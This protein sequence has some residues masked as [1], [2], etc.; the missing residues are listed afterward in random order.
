ARCDDCDNGYFNLTNSNPEGCVACNCNPVG[1]TTIYCDPSSGRCLC[2]LRVQ[3]IKCD[4]CKDGFYNFTSGCEDCLCNDEG[5]ESG[6]VCNKTSGQCTCKSNVEVPSQQP[7]PEYKERSPT[8]IL[9]QWAQPDNPNG[10]LT[11]YSVY[12][13]DTV[14]ANIPANVPS[15][16]PPPEYKERSPTSILLQW[17]QPDNPNGILTS[18]SVYRDDTVVASIPAN[19]TTYNDTGLQPYT[20]YIYVVEVTNAHGSTSSTP[21]IFQ[22]LAGTPSNDA[23][24]TVAD[25]RARS[26]FCSWTP[27]SALNGPLLK[28]AVLSKK[29]GENDTMVEWE[30]IGTSTN[31]TTLS[32]YTRYTLIVETCTAGGCTKNEGK[33]IVT[34]SAPPEAQRPPNISAVNSSTLFVTWDPPLRPNGIISFYEL[35]FRGP[36]D[37]EGNYNPPSSL[38]AHPSGRYD[39]LRSAI[40]TPLAWPQTNF[41]KSGLKPFTEYEFQVLAEND[42]GKVASEWASGTTKEAA[43]KIVAPPSVSGISSTELLITWSQPRPED[44]LGVVQTYR[45]FYYSS[46]DQVTD[47]FSPLYIWRVVYQG[48]GTVFQHTKSGLTPYSEHT[49]MLEACNS[50]ACANSTAVT[51]RT[52]LDV[53]EGVQTPKVEGFNTTAIR[54]SWDEPLFPNGPP[55]LYRVEK[56]NIALSFPASVVRGTRFT[57]G[58][59]YSFQ[60]NVIPQGV[61]FTGIRF[62][63][64]LDSGT[65]ILLF[66][67]S[68]TQEE[69]LAVQF[70]NGRPRFLFDTQG[71]NLIA[72]V[73]TTNDEGLVYNDGKWHSFEA[74]RTGIYGAVTV[75][76][77]WTGESYIR[78]PSCQGTSII[79][80]TEAVYV[81]GFPP[82]FVLRR[83][84]GTRRVETSALKGCIDNIEI[85]TQMYPEEKWRKLDWTKGVTN[86]LAFLNWQGCP[87]NLQPGFHFMGKGYLAIQNC[88][89]RSCDASGN[90]ITVSFR[91]RTTLHTGLL[92]LLYGGSNIYIYSYMDN[93]RL[94]FVL[95]DST[96]RTFLEYSNP[97]VNLCDGQLRALIFHKLGQQARILIEGTQVKA[98]GDPAVPMVLALTS[99]LHVGGIKPESDAAKFV[100]DNGLLVP[101]EG[102]GGCISRL[103]I[104][105]NRYWQE[106]NVVDVANTNLDGCPPFYTPQPEDTCQSSL[107]TQIYSGPDREAFDTGLLPYTD[108]IYRLVAA[109]DAGEGYSSWGYGRT[110]EG[111]PS[112][113]NAP[114]DVRSIS[115]YEVEVIWQEPEITYGLLTKYV[116]MAY[117]VG[118]Q[119]NNSQ[120]SLDIS[121]VTITAVNMTGLV[122]NTHYLVKVKACTPGGC[123]ESQDG[124]QVT[125]PI[126]APEDV[127]A[128]TAESGPTYLVVKWEIP[129]KPNGPITGFFLYQ[130]GIEIYSGSRLNFNVTNLHVYTVYKFH[131]A[132]CTVSGCTEGPSVAIS[133]AQLPPTFV[134][135][136][137]LLVLGTNSIRASWT[138]P[139]RLNGVLKSYFLYALAVSTGSAVPPSVLTD[140]LP[141][142]PVYNSTVLITFTTI[143]DLLAG[144]TYNITLGACTGGGCTL[145]TPAVATTEESA[146]QG[147]QEPI[148]NSPSFSSLEIKWEPPLFPNGQITSY[149]LLQN[150]AE[151]YNG[152]ERQYSVDGLLPYS[153]HTFR[154]RACT[155]QG[156]ATSE[157]V[158]ARTLEMPP[159]GNIV[160]S[161]NVEDA[162]T[163]NVT[164]TTPENLNGF[165]TYYVLAT[166]LYYVSPETWDYSTVNEQRVLLNET[167]GFTTYQLTPLVPM[168][169]Y[170]IQVNGSNSM[171]FILSNIVELDMPPGTPDGMAPPELISETPRSIRATW[172]PV[173]RVNAPEDPAYT[174]QFKNSE[175]AQIENEFG[176]T[177]TL[178]YVKMNLLP[179]TN[180]FFRVEV[181]NSLGYTLSD[182]ASL[183]TA[184]DKPG[185]MGLPLVVGV[186]A[187]YVDLSW[188]APLSPNG[189]VTNYNVYANSEMKMQVH[190][191]ATT[192]RVD[193][194]IP[195]TSYIFEVDVCTI[196]GCTKSPP[197]SSVRTLEDVPMDL[198]PPS[199]KALSPSAIE[200]EYQEPGQPNGQIAEY[201]IERKEGQ[202]DSTNSTVLVA[203]PPEMIKVYVDEANE[204]KPFTVYSY[205]VNVRN[206]AGLGIGPWAVVSTGASRPAGVSPPQVLGLDP[207]SVLVTWSPPL[208]PNGAIESYVLRFPDPRLEVRPENGTRKVVEG[209]T[210]YT[211]YAVTVTACT[212]GGCTESMP[213]RIRTESTIPEPTP[214]PSPTAVSSSRIS[215]LW[216]PSSSPNGPGINYELSRLKLK[217]PLDTTVTDINN[218]QSVYQGVDLFFEDTNLPMFT[219]YIYRVTVFNDKGQS[220]SQNSTQVTT[221]GGLPR[222]PPTVTAEPRDHLSVMV[223]WTLPSPVELQG[224]V[225]S[226]TLEGQSSIQNVTAYPPFNSAGYVLGSRTVL[227]P[228]TQYEITLTVTIY[229]GTS[230]TSEPVEV[231]TLSG[232]PSGLPPPTLAV[233][234]TSGL[235]V[236]W[237]APTQPNGDIISYTI[238]IG[239]QR[240]ETG[241][242]TPGS[243]IVDGLQPYTVYSVSMEAC[244]VFACTTSPSTPGTTAEAPP[245]GQPA[246]VLISVGSTEL[247]ISWT[248]PD[249]PNG[250]IQRYDLWRKTLQKC[251]DI[252]LPTTDPE[253]EKCTYIECGILENQCGRVCYSG[254]KECCDGNLHDARPGYGCCGTDYLPKAS[255]DLVCCAGKFYSPQENF[256]CCGRRYIH[257]PDGEICCAD[258]V[259]N[260]VSVSRGDACCGGIPYVTD[261]AQICCKN[262][263]W[264]RLGRQCCGGKVIPDTTIC[265]G[266]PDDGQDHLPKPG[267]SCCGQEYV[268]TSITLCCVSDTGES[269]VHYYRSN[270]DKL[271]ASDKCCGTARIS[272]NLGCCNYLSYDTMTQV[273]ADR[274]QQIT[275]CGTGVVCSLSQGATAFCNRCDFDRTQL[276]CGAVIGGGNVTTIVQ[277]SNPDPEAICTTETQWIFS[278]LNTTFT[279]TDLKPYSQY[280]YS[281]V[282]VNSAGSARS[283]YI[284]IQTLQAAPQLVQPPTPAVADGQ[285]FVFYVSWTVPER[286]N[287]EITEYNL[288]RDGIELYRGLAL[289]FT[290]NLNIL[291]YTSYSY[292]LS[293]C[294]EAGCT[295]SDLVSVATAQAAPEN[296]L[297]PLVNL[298]SPRQIK[299]MAQSPGLPNGI[300]ISFTVRMLGTSR[301]FEAQIPQEFLYDGLTPYTRYTFDSIVCTQA[302]CTTSPN[303]TV[304]TDQALPEGVSP[305]QIVVVSSTALNLY[306]QAPLQANGLITEYT[307]L[308]TGPP[309]VREEYTG[310]G[311]TAQ[312]R[313]LTPGS[314]L[315]YQLQVTNGAGTVHSIPREIVMPD[316][317][318]LNILPPQSVRVL[319]ST[320][321][322]IMWLPV[323]TNQGEIDQYRVLLNVGQETEV[324]RGVGPVTR[325]VVTEL[326][327]YTTYEIRL[328]ACLRNILNGCGTSPSI[329]VT[330]DEDIPTDL[331]PPIL[332]AV[333]PTAVHVSWQ[334]P[335][336]PNGQITLYRIYQRSVGNAASEI[337]INQ[338][339]GEILSFTHAGQDLQP[340][341]QY[342]YQV[343]AVNSIGSVK[344]NWSLVQTLQAPPQ[345]LAAPSIST[346][347]TYGISVSW[348]PP[349]SPNGPIHQYR[350]YYKQGSDPEQSISIDGNDT[351]TFVSGLLAYTEYQISIGA[352]NDAGSVRS[353]AISV[354]TLEGYPSGIPRLNVEKITTGTAVILTWEPPAQPNGEIIDYR[355][356]QSG[357]SVPVYSGLSQMFE[358]PRLLPFKQYVVSLEACTRAGCTLGEDQSFMTAET[359]PQNQPSPV[360]GSVNA[361]HVTLTWSSPVNPNGAITSYEVLRAEVSLSR[362]R[363]DTTNVLNMLGQYEISP[364]DDIINDPDENLFA[365]CNISN[366]NY[367]KSDTLDSMSF[368]KCVFDKVKNGSL[369]FQ[370]NKVLSLSD[371]YLFGDTDY[372]DKVILLH[373]KDTQS[374]DVSRSHIRS[375]LEFNTNKKAQTRFP[376]QAIPSPSEPIVV[377][378]TTETEGD[379]F[380]WT[381]S[382]LLPYKQYMY[383]V[384]ASNSKDQVTSPWQI[385][386]TEQAAPFGVKP[387]KLAH[388]TNDTNSVL[389][390]W[391]QPEQANGL[392]QGYQVQRNG[393]VPF[394]FPA[395]GERRFVDTGLSAF[396]SYAYSI[397]ACTGGGCTTSALAV[398][399][400]LEAP[401]LIVSPPIITAIDSSSVS[402][403]WIPPQ[404]SNGEVTQYV[405]NMDGVQ[406]YSGLAASFT[407]TGLLPYSAHVFTITACTNG[408]CT[409]S[410]EVTGR[411]ED[412]LPEGLSAPF[413]RV[414]SASAIEIVWS[415]P[416]RPNG[417][418]ESYDVR[419][420]GR[421][422]Y[423][424]SL[425]SN[426]AV[427]EMSYTDY[428]LEAGEEYSYTI[429]ARNRK[430]S[431]ESPSAKAVTYSASPSGLA[432][433]TLRPLT[434]SSIQ[435]DWL[436][437]ASP[438]GMLL[439]Y[440]LFEGQVLVYSGSSDTLSYTVPGLEAYTE[441]SFRVET[442]TAR[443]C[444]VSQPSL[445]RTL[446]APP[447]GQSKPSLLA[448]ADENGTHAGV[449]ITW[450]PPSKP[451]GEIT[452]YD[453]QRR[454]IL[455]G[456]SQDY[457]EA[458]LVYNGTLTGYIDVVSPDLKPYRVYQYMVS[459][460]NSAGKTDSP[461]ET[462]TTREGQPKGV[463]APVVKST[464]STTISVNTSVPTEPNGEIRLYRILVNGTVMSSSPAQ[465]QIVGVNR[466]LQ[467]FTVYELRV[468]ACTSGGC[469]LSSGVI[470]Q[471][472]SARPQ[473]LSAVQ[474]SQVTNES[475]ALTW[476]TPDSPNGVIQRYEIHQRKPCPKTFQPFEQTCVLGDAISIYTGLETTFTAHNLSPY[477]AYEFKLQA[478][479]EEGGVDF[480]QWVR[481]ETQ[482][483]DPLYANYPRMYKNG[484]L[485]MISWPESFILNGRLREYILLADGRVVFRGVTAEHGI[486]RQ[487]KDQLIYFIIQTVTYEGQTESPTIIFDPNAVDNIGTTTSPPVSEE[488][489]SDL[490]FYEEVWFIVLMCLIA[491]LVLIIAIAF[492]VRRGGPSTPYV[493]ERMPLAKEGNMQQTPTDRVAG[494]NG[495]RKAPRDIYVIDASD[496]RVIHANTLPEMAQ[497]THYS[498]QGVLNPA[499]SPERM[500]RA[501]KDSDLDDDDDFDNDTIKWRGKPSDSGLFD[502]LDDSD[503]GQTFSYTKEQT[504]FT[505]THL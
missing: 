107:I 100:L 501:Y 375:I 343:E 105:D 486:E 392:L 362:N 37:A 446:P 498:G 210:P 158:E 289:N 426:A 259:E 456:D 363:R 169:Q 24:L 10:I 194:L 216:Q 439:N 416:A 184:Q 38:I 380:S 19:V 233:V 51:G 347:S 482:A 379:S 349:Q 496:G 189:I 115:G 99:Y 225:Q 13:D 187:R 131:V 206:G 443:G 395:D 103:E 6:T 462:V 68:S 30:G 390:T 143:E 209:L 294:N 503:S 7:P 111:A 317:T 188:S 156:C 248:N 485:A 95:S 336:S 430:G 179:Y 114:T 474:I 84:D 54:I 250:I 1:S 236:S 403:T 73:T 166:G 361:T 293:A 182:W 220:T 153:R 470:T 278:G 224:E 45:L 260:R 488:Q 505:D 323:D 27:P 420:D 76:E 419:R 237:M 499:F 35:Y 43:P 449:R 283:N 139:S 70:V 119:G 124:I 75:D 89:Q 441:Y 262:T 183:I 197:S 369:N 65:G 466:P 71:C 98:I 174:L 129:G 74:R 491:L 435:A 358:F 47:P 31:L 301:K 480:P 50:V 90:N 72:F 142:L 176:P 467:P 413:L 315:T 219:T 411:S 418:I 135:P 440:T 453:L 78:D 472:Q 18:Y 458:I 277:P 438:N 173:G 282:S 478:F 32:P 39:P 249:R 321:I 451:N 46:T 9:L 239:D 149:V 483:S 326:R 58:G 360:M 151:V 101:G 408:G 322:Q 196:A 255:S 348:L 92:F 268:N 146:P 231:K 328:Q 481:A 461:W 298:V 388:L 26:A 132:A 185:S 212:S 214:A 81:G 167:I 320:S 40:D 490:E 342:E 223:N 433:P 313:G 333:S 245:Q 61:S 412:A 266:G 264:S 389:V 8:S 484:T 140:T 504:I 80:P 476:S 215:V 55:P 460:H 366:N 126:E 448:L 258:P 136:P 397:T 164:W 296:L 211:D 284:A 471:T 339:N 14:V 274:S 335:L 332:E 244:T 36:L 21:V 177:V 116:L 272:S 256:K 83:T 447:E 49:F 122:P 299:V 62:R 331:L 271:T 400:T 5:K 222:L 16:Q 370:W 384:R 125:T 238:I 434:S 123:T 288:R 144:T 79:G 203:R 436:P 195:Y 199:L 200:V 147:V 428:N 69:F 108:Y 316:K 120:V 165:M 459:A 218:W 127:P 192:A 356:Y 297:P 117:V 175:S 12:R 444:V 329:N 229:G 64:R 495:E 286:P 431:V 401:P 424:D 310:M 137:N 422:I 468:E 11:S 186:K 265:C 477:T 487:N 263:L 207:T 29:S 309:P 261:G 178:S 337:L 404:I 254:A 157:E 407:V 82:D 48:N 155:V 213:S 354:T 417:V 44:V 161:A 304:I 243:F 280:E 414:I 455:N 442:C 475:V 228:N 330:T 450:S 394:S 374:Y 381:D 325:L 66:T 22:T 34:M 252:P 493:R 372:R 91:M 104:N 500:R 208:Q 53:P 290:D 202:D 235:R 308:R 4:E 109:N 409:T 276:V 241:L 457:S 106:M 376:R 97:A 350:V 489:S 257:V 378:R 364:F 415:S 340:Y 77:T 303:T 463:A 473:G 242:I 110:R 368:F 160:L 148:I 180:Y 398:I 227:T 292:Q 93:G 201:V 402:V 410:G 423:T 28:Y 338:V 421:L 267:F 492:C 42:A 41:T 154:V 86:D 94:V 307:I 382:G 327:P 406:V 306:W 319:S 273:C 251:V 138:T 405:L 469:G 130:D 246:P 367:A 20:S 112:G 88:D 324:I 226:L 454:A 60:P 334:A 232:A 205:R 172:R 247:Q 357:L 345:G 56:T 359:S 230:I 181:S 190:G 25:V 152:L 355:I 59:Y 221:F 383:A 159:V 113:V 497:V 171:G 291:P 128:P 373:D 193:N 85:M 57:G 391:D 318:P 445:V 102:F 275:G 285:L 312:L 351:S 365:A 353:S 133:T 386:R 437:P 198:Q 494:L 3:G 305:P 150:G 163:I 141:G 118:A 17:A 67:A 399:T 2:K 281:V 217:Q 52:L 425:V 253:L 464:T 427:S 429:I 191:N 452:G 145:S 314:F 311:F 204:L 432:P 393:S 170:I 385:I 302:A 121:D 465:E 396:T 371:L 33:N 234:S 287:G 341:K 23:V 377:Y 270:D 15:Q 279:D 269:Q 387:P 96:T 300:I 352:M 502:D 168:S 63:F 479:N 162:R 295:D 134:S 87:I 344:S 346:I 240:V